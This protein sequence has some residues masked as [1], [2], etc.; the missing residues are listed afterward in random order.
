MSRRFEELDWHETP[1]GTIT[2]RR[3]LDP[4]S[5]VDIYEAKLGDEFLMSSLFTAAEIELAHLGLAPLSQP[6]LDVVVGGLGLG[7]TARAALDHP[8]LRTLT[9][10]EA[11]DQVIDW[12]RRALLPHASLLTDDPRC[13]L[14]HGDFFALTHTTG[15]DPELPNR[16]FHAILLDID[17]SPHH[18]LNPT[19]AP[20]Y[21]PDGLHALT[22]HLHPNGT[23]AMWSDGLPDEQFTTLLRTVFTT[24][25]AHTITFPNPLLGGQSASTV[26]VATLT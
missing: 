25:T 3:R 9:V 5:K 12:H 24:A 20:F 18:L 10:V 14:L 11:L 7:Y 8:R 21:T 17:H 4:V 26:Y 6:D 19:H 15:Y 1:M 2:L 16:R 13:H 23:F 22:R